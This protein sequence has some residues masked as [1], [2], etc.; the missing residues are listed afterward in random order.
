MNLLSDLQKWTAKGLKR[1]RRT[2]DHRY[3][4]CIKISGRDVV[5][6]SSNDY[7]G[8]ANH[9]SINSAYIEGVKRYGFGSGASA[10]I[11]GYTHDQQVL[12]E[13]FASWL[14][15]DRTLLFNSG[16][17]ANIGVLSSLLNRHTTILSDKLCHAS[18]LD[19]I[20]LSRARH[21]RYQHNSKDHFQHLYRTVCPDIV[22]TESVFSMEGDIVNMDILKS[23]S[24]IVIDDAHGIGVLGSTGRGI[25]EYAGLSEDD[26]ICLVAP[27]GKAF[28]ALGAI[29]AGRDAVIETLL[30]F[31]KSYRYTTALPPAVHSALNATLSIVI[32]DSWRRANLNESVDYFNEVVD[33]LGLVLASKDK[34][35]IRS[36]IIG[37]NEKVISIQNKLLE[38]GFFVPAIRS[39]TVPKGTERLR[40]S[41][42]CHHTRSQISKFLEYVSECHQAKN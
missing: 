42:N 9:P 15:V 7:L 26:Y 17:H 37:D 11:S 5:N 28:N 25:A 23:H 35:P 19:G 8:L 40:V 3:D 31:S 27:L 34:T 14:N 30:Q 21:Y 33:S 38:N 36:I 16:Y 29:V 20:Q 12:E 22:T 1:T 18:I 2:I 10:V 32:S 4:A 13:K 24:N 6:F 41:L 39:P